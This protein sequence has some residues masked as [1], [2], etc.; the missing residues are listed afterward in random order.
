M[1]AVDDA[2]D[3]P[4]AATTI[5]S[6]DRDLFMAKATMVLHTRYLVGDG[7]NDDDDQ[8]ALSRLDYA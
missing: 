1:A 5:C 3:V 7:D 4:R 8:L 2:A 6:L